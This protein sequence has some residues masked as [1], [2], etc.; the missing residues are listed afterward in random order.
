[1]E[2]ISCENPIWKSDK[3]I[4]CKIPI[5]FPI[6]GYS[7]AVSVG[8]QSSTFSSSISNLPPPEVISVFPSTGPAVGETLIN[9]EVQNFNDITNFAVQFVGGAFTIPASNCIKTAS[10]LINCTTPA[11]PITGAYDVKLVV[12]DLSNTLLTGYTYDPAIITDIYPNTGP[13]IGGY[14]ISI[15]G[16]NF[17]TG[18][19]ANAL[20]FFGNTACSNSQRFN[21]SIITCTAPPVTI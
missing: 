6:G 13:G 18:C 19:C 2:T 4:S 17:G 7:V 1:M 12:G 21:D 9:V 15:I 10:N 14:E 3:T 16:K 11:V 8:N 5:D 20:V